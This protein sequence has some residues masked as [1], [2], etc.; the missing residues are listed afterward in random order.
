MSLPYILK[1]QNINFIVFYLRE[2]YFN[3]ERNNA[4]INAPTKKLASAKN[5]N[6]AIVIHPMIILFLF[7]V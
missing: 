6:G 4:K 5:L 3:R 7:H 1:Y 2:P